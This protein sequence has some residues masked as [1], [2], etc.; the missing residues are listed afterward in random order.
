MK[1]KKAI[2]ILLWVLSIFFMLS[3]V[4]LLSTTWTA[5]FFILPAALL[6]PVINDLLKNKM[7]F[8]NK[9]WIK[10][11]SVVIP[12]IIYSAVAPKVATTSTNTAMPSSQNS[13]VVSSA[14]SSSKPSAESS[15]SSE[16]SQ[17]QEVSSNLLP[18]AVSTV[19]QAGNAPTLGAKLKIHY[20]DVGQG[21]SELLE[22]PN[23]QTMLIDA[24]NRENG[25]QV[26]SYIQGLGHSKIDYLVA[27]HPH[28][29]HIGGMTTVVNSLNIGQVYMPKKSTNTKTFENLLSAVKNKGLKVN[30]A[31]SGV[32]MLTAGNLNIDIIAPV[33]MT[34]SDLNQYSAV[35]KVTYGANKFLFMGDSG[36]PSESQITADVSADVLKVGHH[37]SNTSTSQVFLNKVRPKYAVVEV[38]AG[39]SYGH[40]TAATLSKLQKIGATVYRTDNDGTI[41]FTSDAKTITVD[42]KASNK[43]E[44]APPVSQKPAATVQKPSSKAPAVV[45]PSTDNQS[46]T[47]YITDTGS[48]Y[49]RDGCRYLKKSKHPI[50]LKDAK[51]QGYGP[52]SRCNPPQ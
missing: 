33:D 38:G 31:K 36:E 20:I 12:I 28:A 23:G 34:G 52:C 48:K 22:L 24:G 41:I 17:N 19:N 15:E 3:T 21:D 29:D 11:C 43:Q 7:G 9:N 49:H 4:T 47:V 44:Q 27:T 50:S 46:V 37:G 8:N 40:P 25:A 51:A 26:V 5:I 2:D 13:S 35:V 45:A 42:K 14:A 16:S 1:S 39:N 30:T 32:N 18:S 6:N 10:V